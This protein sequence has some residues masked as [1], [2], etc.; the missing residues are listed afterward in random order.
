MKSCDKYQRARNLPA[1][2]LTHCKVPAEQCMQ[3]RAARSIGVNPCDNSNERTYF[4][5]TLLTY[6]KYTELI[7]TC[8]MI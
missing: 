5:P 6:H 7:H 8:S 1:T 2:L 4:Q 3:Y